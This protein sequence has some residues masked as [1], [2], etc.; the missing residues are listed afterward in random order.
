MFSSF[1]M[2]QSNAST[3][4][5]NAK[6]TNLR[7]TCC[8]RM[9]IWFCSFPPHTVLCHPLHAWAVAVHL[10]LGNADCEWNGPDEGVQTMLRQDPPVAAHLRSN[11]VSNG[12]AAFC[13][14]YLPFLGHFFLCLFW[15]SF[16]H[17]FC[18]LVS[19]C[20]NGPKG[21]RLQKLD[22]QKTAAIWP[23]QVCVPP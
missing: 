13:S 15:G 14:R 2:A 3:G 17:T 9:R 1:R 16:S 10:L 23:D 7:Y 4:R 19:H 12:W 18:L 8:D 5:P 20:F 22:A 21:D 6:S 11:H